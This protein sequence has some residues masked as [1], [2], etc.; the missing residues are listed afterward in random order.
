MAAKPSGAR[1]LLPG[2]PTGHCRKSPAPPARDAITL[3]GWRVGIRERTASAIGQGTERAICLQADS[4]PR[5]I[6]LPAEI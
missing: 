4:Q 3:D 6:C 2:A 1:G 5:S